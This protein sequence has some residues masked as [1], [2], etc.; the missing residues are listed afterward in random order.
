MVWHVHGVFHLFSDRVS[1]LINTLVFILYLLTAC[2][3]CFY[4]KSKA[5]SHALLHGLLA[6]AKS[7]SLILWLIERFMLMRPWELDDCRQLKVFDQNVMPRRDVKCIAKIMIDYK[8]VFLWSTTACHCSVS[9]LK[10]HICEQFLRSFW[11]R[12]HL[13][14]EHFWERYLSDV[15]HHLVAD[16]PLMDICLA[17]CSQPRTYIS[18][19]DGATMNGDYTMVLA[20]DDQC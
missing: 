18:P 7:K 16:K 9:F 11:E 4:M 6:L 10:E 12:T 17:I 3:G 14:T 5:L 15:M 13:L 19:G 8:G 1:S 2:V 20:F